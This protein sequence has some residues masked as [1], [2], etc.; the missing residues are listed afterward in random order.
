MFRILYVIACLLCATASAAAQ[1]A[2]D[3]GPYRVVVSTPTLSQYSGMPLSQQLV[4]KKPGRTTASLSVTFRAGEDA[5]QT[6]E[7]ELPT[8]GSTTMTLLLPLDAPLS[9]TLKRSLVLASGKEA[10]SLS[11]PEMQVVPE[12]VIFPGSEEA[13]G[14]VALLAPDRNSRFEPLLQRLGYEVTRLQAREEP[15]ESLRVIVAA[16]GADPRPLDHEIERLGR[17]GYFRRGGILLAMPGAFAPATTGP[18]ALVAA[19]PKARL[20]A[21][22]VWDGWE[23]VPDDELLQELTNPLVRPQANLL[24]EHARPVCLAQFVSDA[25]TSPG[26]YSA[27]TY[28]RIERGGV[29]AS[30]LPLL[31]SAE[32]MPTAALVLK[33]L[34]SMA[35]GISRGQPVR[36]RENDS[37]GP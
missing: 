30:Q 18:L 37:D 27:L 22:G 7:M 24:R 35:T 26:I 33:E 23:A 20:T 10:K 5:S 29:I 11:L 1:V 34:L 15:D 17:A 8:D 2:D 31:E 14:Q 6:L 3:V 4:I 21:R 9:G 19:P 28:M 13:A 36:F 16:P 12:S 32:T 25:E